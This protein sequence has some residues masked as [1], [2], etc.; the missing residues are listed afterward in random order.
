MS[1]I[2]SVLCSLQPY[3]SDHAI[4]VPLKKFDNLDVSVSSCSPVSSLRVLTN[5]LNIPF[6]FL[7][8]YDA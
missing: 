7:V 3:D 2:I 1:M 5:V 6:L 4:H 8:L